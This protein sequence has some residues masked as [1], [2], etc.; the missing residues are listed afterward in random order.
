MAFIRSENIESIV[1]TIVSKSWPMATSRG[2]LNV[3]SPN[4]ALQVRIITSKENG[5][6]TSSLLFIN[7]TSAMGGKRVVGT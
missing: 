7:G 5:G 6:N 1:K 2:L 3:A 4:P